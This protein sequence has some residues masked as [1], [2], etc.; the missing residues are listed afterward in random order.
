MAKIWKNVGSNQSHF[1]FT[2]V[3]L[4][5]MIKKYPLQKQN[6]EISP[7]TRPFTT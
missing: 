4:K 1:S 6:S 3:P 7:D 5:E 2:K